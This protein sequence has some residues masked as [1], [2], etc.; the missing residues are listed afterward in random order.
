METLEVNNNDIQFEV[1]SA[2]GV[3]V[4][5]HTVYTS[6]WGGDVPESQPCRVRLRTY[7]GHKVNVLGAARVRVKRKSRK[8]PTRAG[9]RDRPEFSGQ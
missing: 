8:T 6:L 2:C 7:T 4:L 9:V 5:N 3:T 1:D